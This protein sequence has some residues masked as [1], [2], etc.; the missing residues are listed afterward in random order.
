MINERNV[1]AHG[2]RTRR[3]SRS[4][5]GSLLQL[6]NEWNDSRSAWELE[7]SATAAE[8][9]QRL[10]L[11]IFLSPAL[12]QS[13]PPSPARR[14]GPRRCFRGC[15]NQSSPTEFEARAAN[16]NCSANN[17]RRRRNQ[18]IYSLRGRGARLACA[19]LGNF[20]S[21]F[22]FLKV[23]HCRL[24]SHHPLLKT[25]RTRHQLGR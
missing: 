11:F 3:Q 15:T 1:M 9:V 5:R 22:L 24:R 7:G 17:G 4:V 6:S 19:Y 12:I 8:S 18:S 2:R 13:S 25:S 10:S 23:S 20:P 16:C 14:A 21:V